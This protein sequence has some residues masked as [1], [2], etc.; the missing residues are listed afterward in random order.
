M[1]NY[2]NYP[3]YNEIFEYTSL[4]RVLKAIETFFK[5]DSYLVKNN[6]HEV[7]ITHRIAVYLDEIYSNYN[8]DCEWNK[9]LVQDKRIFTKTL[10][11]DVEII[12]KEWE[13]NPSNLEGE[14]NELL[15]ILR[16]IRKELMNDGRP[17]T[18]T[19]TDLSGDEM[20]AYS[21]QDENGRIIIKNIRPDIVIHHRGTK[22]NIGVIEVKKNMSGGQSKYKAAKHFDLIKLYALTSQPHL[23]YNFGIY[24]EIPETTFEWK[25]IKIKHS[26]FL[27]SMFGK[28]ARNVFEITFE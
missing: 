26:S 22:Q 2:T 25:N 5:L 10:L 16:L 6:L 27:N 19:I 14:D 8:V 1:P 28:K 24:I 9:N 15:N 4:D 13:N 7:A 23:N 3:V 17:N 11:S 20:L 21:D 12:I 18:T